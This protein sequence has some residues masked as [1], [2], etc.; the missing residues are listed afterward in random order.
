MRGQRGIVQRKK[1]TTMPYR[2]VAVN[3]RNVVDLSKYRFVHNI[4]SFGD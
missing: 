2:C 3:C 4:P 1:F